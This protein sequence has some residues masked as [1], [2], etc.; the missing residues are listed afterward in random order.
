MK[1]FI[2]CREIEIFC[3]AT[4]QDAVRAFSEQSY[5]MLTEGTLQAIDRYGNMTEP[6]GALTEGQVITLK[7]TKK[8]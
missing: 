8:R 4:I 6:D 7:K 5:R 3:G 2:G 1:V